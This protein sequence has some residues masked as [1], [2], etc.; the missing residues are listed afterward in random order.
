MLVD[1]H[2]N[3]ERDPQWRAYWDSVPF[4]CCDDSDQSHGF[5][6]FIHHFEPGARVWRL[7]PPHV[8]KLSLH[9]KTDISKTNSTDYFAIQTSLRRL[10]LYGLPS[11]Y[12]DVWPTWSDFPPPAPPPGLPPA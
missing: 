8:I 4:L 6:E 12:P 2:E 3:V 10:W 5:R 11:P 7:N 9:G 1:G